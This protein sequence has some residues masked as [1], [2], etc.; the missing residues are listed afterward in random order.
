V[1]ATRLLLSSGIVNT[2]SYL[3]YAVEAFKHHYRELGSIVVDPDPNPY[4]EWIR[5]YEGQK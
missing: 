1:A 5:I 3:G 2:I 4:P